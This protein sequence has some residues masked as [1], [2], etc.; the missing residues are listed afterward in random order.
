MFSLAQ[1]LLVSQK[2]CCSMELFN[3]LCITDGRNYV[4]ILSA[5]KIY[6]IHNAL[7][8]RGRISVKRN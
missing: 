1:R 2:G 7:R 5:I 3:K 8:H 4:V 6:D